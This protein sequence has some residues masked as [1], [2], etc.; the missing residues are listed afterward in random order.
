LDLYAVIPCLNEELTII[1]TIENIRKVKPSINIIVVDNGSSDSTVSLAQSAKVTVLQEPKKG[2]GFAVRRGFSAIPKTA[3]AVFMTDGDNT[4]GCE[5][6]NVA[7]DLVITKGFDMIIGKRMASSLVSSHLKEFRFGHKIGNFILSKIFTLLFQISIK[8]TLSGWR[9]MSGGFVA[10]FP[11]GDSEFEIEAELN[12]HA[13]SL[14]TSV[15]EIPVSYLPRPDFSISKLRTYRDGLKILRRNIK[16]FRNN[17]P[18]LGFT[19]LAS[20]WAIIGSILNYQAIRDFIETKTVP[21]FPSL[22]AGVG[23]FLIAGNLWVTGMVIERVRLSRND[24]LRFNYREAS[25]NSIHLN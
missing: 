14:S 1:Q 11:G 24:N 23:C 16:L 19:L 6:L 17:R 9:V 4:Y 18:V 10:S 5:N 12:V 13:F 7:L 22:I 25:S 2:K 21:H 8:D 15:T 3:T 20:P